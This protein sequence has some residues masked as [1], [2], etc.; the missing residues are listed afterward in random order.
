MLRRVYRLIVDNLPAR[1]A[2][3]I[4]YRLGYHTTFYPLGGPMNGQ[5]V[6]LEIA[7]SIIEKCE[8]EQIIE[9]GAYRGTTTEWFSQFG[10]PVLSAELQARFASFAQRRMA[11]RPNVQ[12]ECSDSIA[13]LKRWSESSEVVSRRTLFYLDAHWGKHL[14]LCKE[15]ELISHKF[16][17]WIVIIDDFKVP[18]DGDYGYD[19]YGPGQV[20]D[21]DYVNRCN[22]RD[23]IAFFP[24][25]MGKWETGLKRGCLILAGNQELATKCDMIPLLRP[26]TFRG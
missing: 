21:M 10:I 25:V 6:R 13:A 23:A 16:N 7:R 20:L 11:G 18:S 4:D 12:I 17:S 2:G 5:T 19:D 15:L 26:A 14:P 24:K 22:I 8:V 3:L 9:T 1:M